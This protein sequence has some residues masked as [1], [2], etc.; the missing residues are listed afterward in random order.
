MSTTPIVH[1]HEIIRMV[2]AASPA[3]TRQQLIEAARTRF[4]ADARFGT[5]SAS[6]MTLDELL[7]FL[8][9]RGKVFERDG[10]MVADIGQMCSGEGHDHDHP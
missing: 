4:G 8:A 5:C 1:G 2:H 10:R 3:L 7:A 9:S 6:G